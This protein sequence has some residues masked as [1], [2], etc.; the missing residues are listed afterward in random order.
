M[1]LPANGVTPTVPVSLLRD[2]LLSRSR[3]GV[4]ASKGGE[5][6]RVGGEFRGIRLTGRASSI[7]NPADETKTETHPPN[8]CRKE[9]GKF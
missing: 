3:L 4:K 8:T 2:R 9:K 5:R 7:K 6:E 1:L